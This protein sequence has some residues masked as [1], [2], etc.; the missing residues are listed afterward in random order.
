MKGY[1]YITNN[2]EI[3]NQQEEIQVLSDEEF[4]LVGKEKEEVWFNKLFIKK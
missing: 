1:S 2:N 4:V 3:V